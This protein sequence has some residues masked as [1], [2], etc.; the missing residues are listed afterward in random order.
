MLGVGRNA[1]SDEI[2]KAYRKLAMQYHP[3]RNPDTAAHDKFK[4]I[5][6]AYTVLSDEN[7]RRTY[8]QFGEEGVNSGFGD[9]GGMGGMSAEEIFAQMFGGGFGG[10]GG[11]MGESPFGGWGGGQVEKR[12]PDMEHV[13]SVT[14]EDI[15]SGKS[16]YVDYQKQVTCAP[17]RGSGAKP[18]HKPTKCSACRGTGTRV[19]TRQM[20]GMIQQ[21]VQEC[22]VCHGQ[23]ETI[24]AGHKCDTCHGNKVTSKNHRLNVSIPKGTK[25]GDVIVFPGEANQ[26]PGA[27]T[28]DVRIHVD[29]RPHPLFKRLKNDDLLID[30][31]ISLSNAL[32]GY[33]FTIQTLDKRLLVIRDV[34]G[35]TGAKIVQPGA[36]K[37]IS[38]EG[39]PSKAGRR[40]NLYIRFKVEFPSGPLIDPDAVN[41]LNKATRQTA[42]IPT[43]VEH[44][45]PQGT[46]AANMV[47]APSSFT[48]E[49]DSGTSQGG[50]RRS[51]RRRASANQGQEAQCAQM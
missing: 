45:L 51:S 43:G 14:L 46:I 24:A 17:C 20:G 13:I 19:V 7:K 48:P 42:H 29:V 37:M 21:S 12:T 31:T 39:L 28:G 23:G 30:Q 35:K 38:G 16:T 1:T 2:K 15:F 6:E 26:H 47:D 9:M 22:G 34:F 27:K 3:D 4:T 44:T 8:D 50:Q 32:S 11:D 36:I 33:E 25:N 40:G 10:M 49:E 18:P 41:T 5:T